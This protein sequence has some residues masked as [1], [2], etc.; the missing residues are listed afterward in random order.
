MS[1]TPNW[2]F[3]TSRSTPGRSRPTP[4]PE[5]APCRST[6]RRA[7]SSTTPTTPQNLF[8]LKEFGNIYT[9]IMNPTP[10]RGRAARSPPS[11]A[12]S[13]RSCSASGSPRRF[14]AILNIA[15]AGDHV[16]ASPSLYGGTVN[17]LPE[18][19]AQARHRGRPSSRT[20]PT[21]SRGAP[22]SARTPSS[23]SA[24]PSPTRSPRS[25]TSRP[26]PPSRTSTACRSSST[27]RSPRPTCI[28]PIEWGADIVV[29]SATKYLGGHGTSIAGVI[30]DSGNFDFGADPEK[31]PE[32]QHARRELPRPR[33]RP[34]PR[35]RRRRSAPT[36]PSSSRLGCSCCA[37]SARRA[38]PF[39]AFLIAQ[40]IE[41]LSAPHRAAPRERPQG[42]G[43]PPGPR[44]GRARSSG[45]PCPTAPSTRSREKYAPR[46]AGRRA[47]L[48]DRGRPRGRQEVRRGA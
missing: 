5:R 44:P 26:S 48:R 24:R 28:R 23:S 27:T 4:P 31:F 14:F 43:V 2:S 42:R 15:E 16:V 35:R 36:S 3:E 46:G 37:T 9:R 1:D 30:V 13:A 47:L 45:R 18:H 17:L 6:R 25:S 38:S 33:L 20:P 8:A 12:A 22:P 10:G 39:N 29:H 32:L 40:G 19:L 7:T 41:T 21:S 34:R 11:R